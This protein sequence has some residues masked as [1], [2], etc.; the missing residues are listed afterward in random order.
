MR[1]L[2]VLLLVAVASSGCFV[3]D[4]IEKGQEIMATHSPKGS[5]GG[6]SGGD[7]TDEAKTPRERLAEYYAAQRSKAKARAAKNKNED[8][9]DAVGSCKKGGNTHFTRRSDCELQGGTFL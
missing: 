4:E 1:I 2:L 7:G 3:F 5:G 8:P 9:G 6:S